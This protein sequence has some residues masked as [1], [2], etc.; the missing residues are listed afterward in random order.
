MAGLS[1]LPKYKNAVRLIN[2][3]R[4]RGD[5]VRDKFLA[6]DKRLISISLLGP[7]DVMNLTAFTLGL[8]A[9]FF[10]GIAQVLG[11]LAVRDLNSTSFNTIRFSSVALVLTPPVLIGGLRS[12]GGEATVLAFLSGVLGLF[13]GTQLFFYCMRRAS[14]HRIIP[15]GNSTPV[16]IVVLAPVLLGEHVSILLPLSVGLVVG[17]AFL[18]FPKKK[19]RDEWGPAIPLT[20]VVALIW[21]L[22]QI[23]RKSAINMGMGV[24]VF[25][26][27]SVIS[28]VVF[29]GLMAGFTRSWENQRF[30][31]SSVGLSICSGVFGHL[32]GNIC[33]LSA[34][35]LERVTALAPL[36]SAVIPFGF[37]LSI[38]IVGEKP[39]RKA[40]GGMIV[41]FS[42]V[43]LA[44]L[45]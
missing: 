19:E 12:Q 27:I 9:A 23:I 4:G 24:L 13:I 30:S 44:A 8:A 22:N 16:W 45:M 35:E 2:L 11:K 20:L 18:L 6:L 28:A 29:L 33:F 3:L 17:G 14:A 10:W 38:L 32:V 26:W 43:V 36:T 42:G 37:L 34:L 21:G 39:T 15:V 40:V 5:D 31:R 1:R 41:V 7:G 25:L